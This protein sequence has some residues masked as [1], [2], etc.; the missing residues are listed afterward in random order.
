MPTEGLKTMTIASPSAGPVLGATT[1]CEAFSLTAAGMA[2]HTAFSGT[3]GTP[4]ASWAEYAREVSEAAAGLHQAGLAQGDP[5][6]LMLTNRPEFHVADAAAL[7][8]GATPFSLYNSAAPEQIVH[9]VSDAG[10]H[11]VVA[12]RMFLPALAA[13]RKLGAPIESI[14]LVDGEDGEGDLS[15]EALVASGG[16]ID[17]AAAAAE[18]TPDHVATLIYTSGTT[19]APKGVELTHRNVT[20]MVAALVEALELRPRPAVISYL[21]MAHIAERLCTHYVPMAL[22]STVTPCPD[23]REVVGLL[24]RVRPHFFFSPPRLW[25]KLAASVEAGL[26]DGVGSLDA[27]GRDA[28]RRR[29][30][31]DRIDSAIVGAAPCPPE[32]IAFWHTLGVPLGEV[33]GMSEETGV[34]TANPPGA[35]RIGSVGKALPGVDVR[36]A[37]DGEVLI[38]GDVVMRGYRNLPGRTA[39]TIDSQGWLHSGDIGELDSDGYLKIVDRKKELIINAAGKNMSP[40]NIEGRLKA[41]SPLIGQAV[42]IG[43]GRP[44]NVALIVLD[45]DAAAVFASGHG[46]DGADLSVLAEHPE[47]LAAV[48]RGVDAANEQLSRVEQIKRFCVL[49]VDWTPDSEE[50]TPTSKLKRRPIA[51]RYASEIDALYA[52]S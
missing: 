1:L 4:G 46:M 27:E 47:L 52:R 33:Y 35:E 9:A 50:L 45:P 13:A 3:D 15:W 39:E 29:L 20:A 12:E 11:T 37:A 51:E 19:G 42:A 7:H 41:G 32:V 5:L 17:L 40:A 34:A 26:P 44:Y 49:G 18:V 28:V 8:L 10:A 21:P 48:G 30:G 24:P 43:D 22:G 31:F 38:R 36:I 23:H 25:E 2:E 14:V 6:A 16:G